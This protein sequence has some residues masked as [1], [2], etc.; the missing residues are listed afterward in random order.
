MNP[1]MLVIFIGASLLFGAP[2]FLGLL[3]PTI[4]AFEYYM[5]AIPSLV[6]PQKM[7][8][9]INTFSLLAV[10]LF[11]FAADII[12]RG[13]IGAR[14][15]GMVE[16]YCRH[17][18]GGLAIASVVACT[19]FGAMSGIGPA[20]IVSIGPI[21]YPALVRQGYSREFSVGLIVSASTLSMMIPPGVSMIL[22]ALT[23]NTSVGRVFLAGLGSGLVF[24]LMLCI[25][26][27]VYA[28]MRDIATTSRAPWTE[29]WVKTKESIFALG[30][31]VTI[32][33]GIYGG[34]ATPT[35]A[36]AFACVYAIIVE[37]FIYKSMSLRDVLRI[38]NQSAGTVSILL[39]LVAAGTVLG[40]LMTITQVSQMITSVLGQNS[41]FQLLLLVN[42][43]FLISGMLIDPNTLV[44]V[45]VPLVF[46]A[47]VQAGVDPIHFGAVVIAN[48]AV[49]ML[50][51]PFGLN[52]FIAITTF[53]LSYISV[54]RAIIPFILIMLVLLI[55]I[56]YIPQ[57]SLFF[58]NMMK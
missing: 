32:I 52:L 50:S 5:P 29:R 1:T 25:Y 26:S 24:M 27:Y 30:M 12:S 41:A 9:G 51:P 48:L 14:L 34:I 17:I 55:F 47:L 56:T 33:G 54:V 6:I 23:T 37:C 28:Y 35:E 8:D 11:I 36:A 3:A 18:R 21:V 39:I 40:Y 57:I 53:R 31:P 42:V 10:P 2:I 49:G 45:L 13:A 38:S 20:A 58:P 4:F 44:I 16:S 43:V 19:I 22:Y 15:M 7:V 46:P